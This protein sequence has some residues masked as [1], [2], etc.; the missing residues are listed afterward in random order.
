M[1]TDSNGKPFIKGDNSNA[2]NEAIKR[3]YNDAL[4]EKSGDITE[5]LLRGIRDSISSIEELNAFARKKR[6]LKRTALRL[7]NL[8]KKKF[9]QYSKQDYAYTR[10]F[11][12]SEVLSAIVVYTEDRDTYRKE[13]FEAVDN[14]YKKNI[15]YK[16]L[17]KHKI[18][19]AIML[20]ND[21][22]T[23]GNSAASINPF[24]QV[25][26]FL[27]KDIHSFKD[28]ADTLGEV[29]GFATNGDGFCHIF[30][31]ALN[32]R[33][34]RDE[35]IAHEVGHAFGLKHTFEYTKEKIDE[36]YQKK[37][38]EI[39][40]EI[41][42]ESNNNKTKGLNE[43][44]VTRYFDNIKSEIEKENFTMIDGAIVPKITKI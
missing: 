12:D 5:N 25:Y 31:L 4:V 39:E 16:S 10:T 22:T 38:K 27:Y 6:L 40:E 41:K 11:D 43:K 42:E 28:S 33:T 17:D 24:H 13:M 34:Q 35:L 26:I 2:F 18:K 29:A 3:A 14:R 32:H 19:E 15:H 44:S 23:L 7:I 9:E 21:V 1:K 36:E 20:G 37:L 30:N 8:I